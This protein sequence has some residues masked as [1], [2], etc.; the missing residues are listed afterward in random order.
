MTRVNVRR[1][2]LFFDYNRQHGVPIRIARIFNTYGPRMATGDGRAVRNFIVQALENIPINIY[3]DGLQSRSFCYVDD[4]IG[5]F[6]T[7]TKTSDTLVWP[8]NLGNPNEFTMI[9]LATKVMEITG[10]S[11]ELVF[12]E[13]P[14][15]DPKQRQPDI[16]KARRM[17]WE[18]QVEIEE[19]LTRTVKSFRNKLK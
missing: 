2:R 18:P 19:G 10:S 3:G 11:S 17:G 9:E 6:A 15:D 7:R 12:E 16:T 14:K 8:V 4:L 5:V 1:K 13:L